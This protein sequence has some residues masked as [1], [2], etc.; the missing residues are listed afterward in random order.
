MNSSNR[1]LELGK[2]SRHINKIS[3]AALLLLILCTS[4]TSEEKNAPLRYNTLTG[5]NILPLQSANEKPTVVIFI[6][7]DCPI[8]NGYAPEINRIH[9]KYSR[10]GV[11][12]TLV[13]VDPDLSHRSAV[14]HAKDYSLTPP[15]IL[16]PTHELVS[17]VEA[18]ITP[19]AA[20]YDSS[21]KR[22]YLGR[23]DNRYSGLGDRRNTVTEHNL[24]FAIDSALSGKPVED[25]K[26][27]AIGCLI[28]EIE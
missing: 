4:V 9:S 24:R 5:E 6:T 27:K 1:P 17:K 10:K 3:Y 21:G 23:I 22:I 26:T 12:I 18:T 16:D 2:R 19:E 20:V 14:E 28:P 8:A 15:I 13:H 25:A 7:T 11:Q